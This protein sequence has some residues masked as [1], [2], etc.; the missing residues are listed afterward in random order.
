M[1]CTVCSAM[2]GA[3]TLYYRFLRTTPTLLKRGNISGTPCMGVMIYNAL[4]FSTLKHL[5]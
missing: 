5:R 1:L 4:A 3:L 2:D